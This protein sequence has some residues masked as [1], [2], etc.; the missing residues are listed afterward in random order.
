M[1]PSI[2][3]IGRFSA[4]IAKKWALR[5]LRKKA[6]KRIRIS[7]EPLYGHLLEKPPH[8]VLQKVRGWVVKLTGYEK[9]I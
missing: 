3:L 4:F 1:C 5:K 9:H 6:P 7:L 2:L 8:N